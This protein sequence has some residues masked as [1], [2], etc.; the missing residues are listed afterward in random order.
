MERACEY[1]RLTLTI[2]LTTLSLASLQQAKKAY[3]IHREAQFKPWQESTFLDCRTSPYECWV[4][5]E[6]NQVIGYAILL[7]VL[8]EVTLMDIAISKQ[9]RGRGCGLHMLLHV[10]QR[11]HSLQARACFLEVRASNHIAIKL[12]QNSGFETLEVRKGYYPSAN[13][14]EDAIMMMLACSSE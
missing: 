10:R 3:Q 13:G 9:Q 5:V 12:Y 4:M 11:C 7:V 1:G 6:N 2:P 14:R 8:N